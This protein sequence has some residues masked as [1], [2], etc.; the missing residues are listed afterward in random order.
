MG[1]Y[2]GG[3]VCGI[4]GVGWDGGFGLLFVVVEF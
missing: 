3:G 2:V 4:F 1:C